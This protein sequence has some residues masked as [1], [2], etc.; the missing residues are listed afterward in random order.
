[1]EYITDRL[2]V[3]ILKKICENNDITLRSFSD[4]WLHVLSKKSAVGKILGYKFSVNDSVASAIAQ[5]KVAT[6]QLLTNYGIVAAPHFLVRTKATTNAEW[7]SH[8]WKTGMIIKPLTGTGGHAIRLFYEVEAAMEYMEQTGIEAWA[9]SPYLDILSE[10]R[11]IM[12]DGDVLLSYEKIPVMHGDVKMFN[13]G[14]G[15]MAEDAPASNEMIKAAQK[16]MKTLGLRL[17]AVDMIELA[18][19]EKMILEVNDGIMM[20]YYMRSS[21]AHEK[22]G[23]EVYE[24]IILATLEK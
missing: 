10:T 18:T 2:L 7:T 20:E 24:E 12:L 19:G 3:R 1:V 21:P 11:L 15:A 16:A 17:A 23:Y 22:R 6:Y 13:L 14:L 4:D 5:D 8:P 9:V